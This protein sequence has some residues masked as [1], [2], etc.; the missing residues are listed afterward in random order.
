MFCPGNRYLGYD[1]K[2]HHA[3]SGEDLILI[4]TSLNV[5]V[6]VFFV[7]MEDVTQVSKGLDQFF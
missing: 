5:K 3:S 4:L 2:E 1:C 7:A 6:S